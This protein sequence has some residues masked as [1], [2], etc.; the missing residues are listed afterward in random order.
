MSLTLLKRSLHIICA[1]LCFNLPVFLFGQSIHPSDGT[2]SVGENYPDLVSPTSISIT[3]PALS[4]DGLAN[5]SAWELN[6]SVALRPQK[7]SPNTWNSQTFTYTPTDYEEGTDSITW[8]A[9]RD[10]TITY[11]TYKFNIDC[12]GMPFTIRTSVLEG[13]QYLFDLGVDQQKIE[14]GTITFEVPD[15]A[16]DTLFY[17][18]TNDIN[19]YGEFRIYDIE[20]NSAIDV[21]NE[22]VGKKEYTLSN[23]YSL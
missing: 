11:E 18:S 20:E 5:L 19:T 6:N 4:F 9:L 17:Q 14:Q 22:V 12:E 13:D 7:G 21:D 15:T 3:L 10:D 8:K 2:Y 23:G 1:V 16:P